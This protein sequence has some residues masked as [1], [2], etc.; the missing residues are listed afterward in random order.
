MLYSHVKVTRFKGGTQETVSTM[1]AHSTV[2][3]TLFPLERA[4][5]PMGPQNTLRFQSWPFAR[6]EWE[7]T[8]EM[9]KGNGLLFV[10]Y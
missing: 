1:S 8:K 7:V 9:E 10:L 5:D 2:F 6:K 4:T 3:R